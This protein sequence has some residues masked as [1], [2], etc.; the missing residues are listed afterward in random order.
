MADDALTMENN[1][2]DDA[3]TLEKL[4]IVDRLVVVETHMKTGEE[5]RKV[6]LE[7]FSKLENTVQNIETTLFGSKDH[8][9]VI[10]QM[11]ALLK[12]ADSIKWV[13]TKIFMAICTAL[14][15]AMLPSMFGYFSKILTHST[16]G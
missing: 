15:L 16:G 14:T 7:G 1:M 6:L 12:V 13:L 4:K 5:T 11:K 9:G 2:A 10:L 3:L 8:D